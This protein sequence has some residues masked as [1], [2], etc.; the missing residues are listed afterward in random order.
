M[1]KR[2]AA[3]WKGQKRDDE[4]EAALDES[5]L[6]DHSQILGASGAVGLK[7]RVTRG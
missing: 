6:T 7:T 3:A 4:D 1:L 5:A 2:R